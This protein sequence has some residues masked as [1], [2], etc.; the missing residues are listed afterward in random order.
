MVRSRNFNY[1]PPGSQRMRL[2]YG[3]LTVQ[4]F[5]SLTRPPRFGTYLLKLT[6]SVC[7]TLTLFGFQ[8]P[9]LP[10]RDLLPRRIY[11][12][13]TLLRKRQG[14]RRFFFE[15]S[16]R[17]PARLPLR[18]APV[19]P[20]HFAQQPPTSTR[21]LFGSKPMAARVSSISASSVLLDNSV[22]AP[23]RSQ[24]TCICPVLLPASYQC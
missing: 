9:L 4:R 6:Q 5:R 10:S 3:C 21:T 13:T 1:F 11:S 23:H 18:T 16:F 15:K 19:Q 20:T 2:V 8:G 22:T 7:C 24:H 17:P 14:V 12:Y